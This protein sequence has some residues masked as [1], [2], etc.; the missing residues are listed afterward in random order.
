MYSPIKTSSTFQFD[1]L[2]LFEACDYQLEQNNFRLIRHKKTMQFLAVVKLIQ[3]HFPLIQFPWQLFVLLD[4]LSCQTLIL[5]RIRCV[6]GD[7]FCVCASECVAQIEREKSTSVFS[8]GK[9]NE[10]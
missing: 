1:L 7:F 5:L 10:I 2:F 4:S 3:F 8:D 9:V 6:K